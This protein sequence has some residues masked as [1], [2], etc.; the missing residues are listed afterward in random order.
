[1]VSFP[2]AST[3]MFKNVF[4]CRRCKT[5]IRS[6]AQKIIKKEVACRRCGGKVFRP[7]RKVKKVAA[8]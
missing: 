8:K 1:M 6:N 4:V 7:I 3:R 5:K 2:E